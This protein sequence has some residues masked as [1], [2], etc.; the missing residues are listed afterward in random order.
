MSD[1]EP[2][3]T[4]NPSLEYAA[5][6]RRIIIM[7]FG[8]SAIMGVIYCFLPSESPLDYVITLPILV[9][10]ISWCLTDAR[11]RDLKLGRL[12]RLFLIFFFFHDIR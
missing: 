2:L 4:E 8:Y 1:E 7:L 6:K 5:T 9:M 10:A 12:W 11:E 3:E